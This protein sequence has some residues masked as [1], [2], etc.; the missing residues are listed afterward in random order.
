LNDEGAGSCQH[1]LFLPMGIAGVGLSSGPDHG[2]EH[3]ELL[4]GLYGVRLACRQD[5]GLTG[6]QLEGLAGDEHLSVTIQDLHQGIEGGGVFAEFL[7]GVEGKERDVS[8][9]GLGDLA[10]DDGAGLVGS[11]LNKFKYFGF[12]GG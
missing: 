7:P 1:L 4:G 3:F 8:G 2:Q 12:W 11:H 10:A 9:F 6:C 5:D